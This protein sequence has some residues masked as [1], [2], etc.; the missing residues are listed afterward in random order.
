MKDLFENF[1]EQPEE[2]AAILKKYETLEGSYENLS[3]LLLEV[4][5]IGFTFEWGM[6]GDPYG[7]RPIEVPLSSLEGF[8]F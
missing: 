3:K 5:A 2:L 6:D 4:E 8:N 1:T 7:L